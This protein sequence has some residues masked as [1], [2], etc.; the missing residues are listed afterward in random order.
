MITAASNTGSHVTPFGTKPHGSQVTSPTSA[1]PKLREK[2]G[3][4]VG[5][6]FYGQMLKAM[7]KTQGKPAYFN[8]GRGEEAFQ[9]QLDQVLAEKM[10]QSSGDSLSNSMYELFNLQRS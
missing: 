2:F 5:E 1:D 6:T 3:Q 9:G 10:S 4:F 8:G 7:H